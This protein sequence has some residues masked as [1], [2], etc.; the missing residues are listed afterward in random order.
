MISLEETLFIHDVLVQE[1]GGAKG[2]RDP[3]LLKSA[4]QRPYSMFDGKEL[5]PGPVQKAAVLLEGIVQNHPFL[6][7]NKRVGYALM[8]LQLINAGLDLKAS[9]DEKYE[10]VIGVASGKWDQGEILDWLHEHV[11]QI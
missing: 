4:L 2:V 5:F 11:I 10:L 9:Q 7:G 6:D 3:G 8:R 1:F